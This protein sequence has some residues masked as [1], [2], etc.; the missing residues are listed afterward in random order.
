MCQPAL[1]A[2]WTMSVYF[3]A[4]DVL[5]CSLPTCFFRMGLGSQILLH[6]TKCAIIVC[7]SQVLACDVY[8]YAGAYKQQMLCRHI[9]SSIAIGGLANFSDIAKKEERKTLHQLC[10]ICSAPV[11]QRVCKCNQLSCS[12][13]TSRLTAM[14]LHWLQ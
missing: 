6:R 1:Q 2:C 12:H 4:L 3:V 14:G 7:A 9:T 13:F 8:L 5:P 11:S 10:Y